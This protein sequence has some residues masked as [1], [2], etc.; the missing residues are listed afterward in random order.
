MG[1]VQKGPTLTLFFGPQKTSFFR[2]FSTFFTFL[3]KR[4]RPTDAT[5]DKNR[6]KNRIPKKPK[7]TIKKRKQIKR[8][9]KRPYL[10]DG[11]DPAKNVKKHGHSAQKIEK[12]KNRQKT[13]KNPINGDTVYIYIGKRPFLGLFQHRLQTME[14][15]SWQ[16]SSDSD[17]F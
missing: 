1:V 6:S 10:R 2:L 17:Q 11:I 4:N 14:D 9:K 8:S 12:P 16:E 13:S 15:H 3:T 5:F 7:K